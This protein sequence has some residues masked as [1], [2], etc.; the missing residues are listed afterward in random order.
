MKIIEPSFEILT[1]TNG[2][3]ILRA[4]EKVAR[5]CY[6]S[7]DRIEDGSA[8]RMILMLIKNGHEAMI[9]FFDITVKFIH[10]RGFSHEM[11]RHRLCSFAQESTRYCNYS[12][13]KFGNEI[14]VIRPYWANE[15]TRDAEGRRYFHSEAFNRWYDTIA[16]IENIYSQMLK[17]GL[18]AQAARGILPNDLKTEINV[19]TNLRE[20]RQIFKL[21]CAPAAHPD[22]RRVMIPLLEE[23][24]IRIPVIFDD[25]D[26]S[27]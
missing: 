5:T 11:V 8:E 17:L 16:Y 20:W 9:E 19:K 23:L 27:K 21:R 18:P 14:T 22:M 3:E 13:N 24:K 26:Y 15:E 1:H 25:I 10:N 4:I 12:A 7:E 6:K 2:A